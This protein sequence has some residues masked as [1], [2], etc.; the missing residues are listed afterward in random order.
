MHPQREE[1]CAGQVE[2]NK[3]NRTNAPGAH[4]GAR[5]TSNKVPFLSA[6]RYFIKRFTVNLTFL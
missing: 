5:S 6:G 1:N 2:V 3:K 4:H